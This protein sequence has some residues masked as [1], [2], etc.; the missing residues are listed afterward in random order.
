VR[1][2]DKDTFPPNRDASKI[3]HD[4]ADIAIRRLNVNTDLLGN[5][6]E[7]VSDK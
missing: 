7:L 1:R 3:M 2:G 5:L 4:V 6:E